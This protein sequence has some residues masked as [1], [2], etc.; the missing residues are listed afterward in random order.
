MP[1]REDGNLSFLPKMIYSDMRK[2][3][4]TTEYGTKIVSKGNGEI[5]YDL[6]KS[7]NLLRDMSKILL[8]ETN[9]KGGSSRGAA[10]WFIQAI[11]RGQMIVPEE[12]SLLTAMIDN[13]RSRKASKTYLELEGRMFAFM[14]TPRTRVKLEYYDF[15]PL[16]ITLGV[17][18]S[19]NILG[20][21]LHYLEPDLRA[22]LVD[23]MLSF[24]NRRFGEKMPPKGVGNFIIDYQMLKSVRLIMGL[25]CLRSYDPAR[26]IGNP[27]LIPSN[28]WGNAVALPFENF[29][30]T[31]EKRVFLETRLKIRE[32]I[33]SLGMV[34]A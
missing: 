25:P 17:N 8:K 16:V 13:A 19:G 11:E 15:T 14:Y 22:E 9:L 18:D 31:T 26:I 30:K 23:K 28:E 33:R 34:G 5:V 29:V 6:R 24:S 10:E 2:N 32:F 4:K 7:V 1:K 21:N 27:V 3:I 12:E 20:I